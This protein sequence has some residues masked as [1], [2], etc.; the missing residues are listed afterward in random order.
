MNRFI[1]FWVL[2][3]SLAAFATIPQQINYQ[4]LLTSSA[5]APLD[6]TVSVRFRLYS[7]SAGTLQVWSE[8][9]PSVPV[10]D[11]LFNI[12][13]GL[14]NPLTD[15][16]LLGSAQLWL[17][18]TIGSNSQMTPLTRVAAVPFSLRTR[19]VNDAL[20][21]TITSDLIVEGFGMFGSGNDLDDSTSFVAGQD[22]IVF[23]RHSAIVS[24]RGNRANDSL[25]FIGSGQS[26][27][28]FARNGVIGGGGN[29]RVRGQ[30]SVIGGG[31]G[32]TTAD[33][34]S[35]SGSSSTIGGGARN[36]VTTNNSTVGGGF[37]N[38]VTGIDG[39]IGGGAI[40][41]ASGVGT[42]V[43]GGLF[44]HARG[45]LSVVGGGGGFLPVD[46]NTA[47][48]TFSVV[49]GGRRNLAG[50]ASADSGA[51]VAGGYG[52]YAAARLSVVGGGAGNF[53]GGSHSLVSGGNSNDVWSHHS[54]V[55]GGESNANYA[56][57]SS[58]GGGF[59]NLLSDSASFSVIGGGQ[60]NSSGDDHSTIGGGEMNSIDL[61]AHHSTIG[62]G[63]EN[64]IDGLFSTIPGGS[65][66]T[67]AGDFSFAAGLDA[68]ADHNG[69]FIW[70]DAT[71]PA[72]GLVTSASNQFT[73]RASGG[74]RLFS[75]S[76]TTAGVTLAA[77]ASAWG[78]VSDSSK[79]ENIRVVNTEGVLEKVAA[80]KISEWNYKAQDEKI[81]H[82][83][84]MAQDFYAAFGLGESDTTISTIDPDGV[85][86][87]AV[88]E[89]AKQSVELKSTNERLWREIEQLR[90]AVQTMQAAVKQSDLR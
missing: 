20:G 4:G 84:P 6:T 9:W 62:G 48:S 31:G 59:N 66:N 41:E 71:A 82:I 34:N 25:S 50:S 78:V 26:N 85:L 1:T 19:T 80:L 64:I 3:I 13:M 46:S 15:T 69:C 8:L 86:F 72:G 23:S 90:A 39:T 51:V 44:N 14:N 37:N 70:A 60:T 79:K 27:T 74:Y 45:D 24:G 16:P 54:G 11:G 47:L 30:F 40:N 83:G 57:Y 89:L 76:A 38:R 58:I 75:N 87:A 10:V 17:G 36:S 49:A 56:A 33:S 63:F 29:N 88:Q 7:D 28:T 21:G 52:N 73:T 77:G 5:G 22:N 2:A 68:N 53:V 65:N 81:R 61:V 35:V 42:V 43:S 18:V 32:A 12:R 55:V 67:C